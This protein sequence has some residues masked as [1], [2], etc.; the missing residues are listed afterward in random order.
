MRTVKTNLKKHKMTYTTGLMLMISCAISVISFSYNQCINTPINKNPLTTFYNS[1]ITQNIN[2]EDIS[3]VNKVFSILMFIASL[4]LGLFDKFNKE[5]I[6]KL[7]MEIDTL[8]HHPITPI[9]DNTEIMSNRTNYPL[10]ITITPIN[11]NV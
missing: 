6:E 11:N 4:L 2:C 1:T 3:I 8:T 7:K 5:T 10:A 9:N